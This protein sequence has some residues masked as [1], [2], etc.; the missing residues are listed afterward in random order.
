MMAPPPTSPVYWGAEVRVQNPREAI[1]TGD[2]S[3]HVLRYFT[4]NPHST[5]QV[6]PGLTFSDS[7]PNGLSHDGKLNRLIL[8]IPSR[9]RLIERNV[10]STCIDADRTAASVHTRRAFRVNSTGGFIV[11]ITIDGQ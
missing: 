10:H 6:S 1:T 5:A 3:V 7:V 11:G 4:D 2:S 8:R 9:G